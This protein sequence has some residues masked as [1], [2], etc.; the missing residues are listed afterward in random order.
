[1]GGPGLKNKALTEL[2]LKGTLRFGLCGLGV[3]CS[4]GLSGHGE[5]SS[6]T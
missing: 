2:L 4:G 1:M 5:A 3:Y 6:N